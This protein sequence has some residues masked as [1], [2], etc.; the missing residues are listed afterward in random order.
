MF[1]SLKKSRIT[2]WWVAPKNDKMNFFNILS[3]KTLNGDFIVMGYLD[4]TTE[5]AHSTNSVVRIT[6]KGVITSKGTFY[7]FE[8]AHPLYLRFL[9]KANTENTII[10]S[11]WKILDFKSNTMIADILTKEGLIKDVTF[12]FIK[13]EEST[14]IFSGYS[15]KLSSNIVVSTFRRKDYCSILGLPNEVISDVYNT[16]ICI[17]EDNFTETVNNVKNLFYKKFKKSYIS[18]I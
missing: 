17:F 16:S 2:D 10:A 14:V 1:L 15:N 9:L 8:E 4:K 18:V 7:P 5:L 3:S 12:D 13:D 11:Y 6:S